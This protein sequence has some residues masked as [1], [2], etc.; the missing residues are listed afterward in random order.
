MRRSGQ[1]GI[2]RG[3]RFRL[4]CVPKFGT[5]F[6]KVLRFNLLQKCASDKFWHNLLLLNAGVNEIK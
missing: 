4:Y 6:S 2:T 1:S 5:L 3:E